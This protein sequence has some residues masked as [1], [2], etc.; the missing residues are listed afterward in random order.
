MRILAFALA[1]AVG[2]G[3]ARAEAV[4]DF[5]ASCDGAPLGDCLGRVQAA[6]ERV[7]AGEDGH[8]F[9]IPPVWGGF[10]PSTTYPV[11][12]L[13][14]VR[15][16]LSAARIGRAGDPADAVVRSVLVEMFPCREAAR[17]R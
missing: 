10:V 16:R 1:F 5:V 15:L 13:D 9:C 3:T 11:S 4:W 6:I 7:R 14:Y 8:A 12:V 2:S 17:Q